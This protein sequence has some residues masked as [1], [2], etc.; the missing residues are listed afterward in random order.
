MANFLSD[1]TPPQSAKLQNDLDHIIEMIKS[2]A[3][4]LRDHAIRRSDE[5]TFNRESPIH[6]VNTLLYAS[7]QE[8]KCT[9][10]FVGYLSDQQAGG[11]TAVIND[12]VWIVTI[13]KRRLSRKEKSFLAA[14]PP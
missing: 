3:F 7:Y 5:R 4:G 10:Q 12:G 1:A 13:F 2:N 8:D 14:N 6:I 9:Y 11:F